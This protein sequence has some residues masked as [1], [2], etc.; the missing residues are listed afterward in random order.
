M[1]RV[2]DARWFVGW[3][4]LLT[5][6]RSAGAQDVVLALHTPAYLARSAGAYRLADS[7]TTYN[8]ATQK[9]TARASCI[10]RHAFVGPAQPVTPRLAKSL[11]MER[12]EIQ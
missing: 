7:S 5:I 10:K 11:Q 6:T 12:P 2:D 3:I 9:R 4:V 8:V 1:V